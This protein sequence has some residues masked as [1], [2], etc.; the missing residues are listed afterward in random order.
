M[1]SK[2]ILSII[3]VIIFGVVFASCEKNNRIEGNYNKTTETR[4]LES[5]TK[6]F[7]EG[8]YNL[9]VVRDSVSEVVIEA[10]SN[11][12]AHIRTVV[13][14]NELTIDSRENLNSNLPINILVRTPDIN[15]FIQSGTGSADVDLLSGE[16]VELSVSGT[17]NLTANIEADIVYVNSSGSNDLSVNL[18]SQQIYA[19]IDGTGQINL[20]G[21]TTEGEFKST[22]TG[23]IYANNLIQN[24]LD[25]D[26]DGS[27]D[28][29]VNASDNLKVRI[30]GN[31]SV[32]YIGNPVLDVK[33]TGTGTVSKL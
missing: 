1:K 18:E 28:M 14:G 29:S 26:I 11:I 3:T 24:N 10:E 5:F 8:D 27:G 13:N 20:S 30:S 17:A 22:G 31:G 6:L 4:K 23:N 9:I 32:Y 19:S 25:V 21:S 12:V 16:Y 33:I 7:I 2:Q 15:S